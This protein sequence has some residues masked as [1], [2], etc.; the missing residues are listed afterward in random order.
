LEARRTLVAGRLRR[1]GGF[2]RV[3]EDDVAPNRN[4]PPVA[5]DVPSPVEAAE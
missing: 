4:P 3:G 5:E 1:A 2:A